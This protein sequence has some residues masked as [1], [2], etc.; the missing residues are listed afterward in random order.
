MEDVAPKSRSLRR[1]RVKAIIIGIAFFFP[2]FVFSLALTCT[3]ANYYYD[4]EAQAPL[5]AIGPSFVIGVVAAIA[6][7]AHLLKKANSGSG[8][9]K[10]W[11]LTMQPMAG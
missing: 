8:T 6:C 4:G 5:G 1:A 11:R 2:S 3:W 10:S 9:G 7:T